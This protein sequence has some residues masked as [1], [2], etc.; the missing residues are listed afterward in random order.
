MEEYLMEK[1]INDLTLSQVE[2]IISQK[3]EDETDY[4]V[5]SN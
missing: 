3:D 2:F 5:I 4:D 1:N